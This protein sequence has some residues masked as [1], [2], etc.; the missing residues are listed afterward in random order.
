MA[1][2]YAIVVDKATGK[3]RYKSV[4]G[5]PRARYMNGM[6]LR[7]K[8]LRKSRGW[9]QSHVA[10]LAG[11]SSSY[12][13]DIERGDKQ[14]NANRMRL[15]AQAFKVREQDLISGENNAAERQF[16]ADMASLS[17]EE[18]DLVRQMAARLASA[19]T[20]RGG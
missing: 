7:L 8:E 10:D 14:I 20:R 9:T 4:T 5:H 11:M 15:L 17:S 2:S 6:K 13:A 18:Q 1:T 19:K 12:Y 16:I 3:L